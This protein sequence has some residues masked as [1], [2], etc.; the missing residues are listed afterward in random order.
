MTTTEKIIKYAATAFAA[1]IAVGIVVT[2][3]EFG[4]CIIHT[5]SGGNSNTTDKST[6]FSVEKVTSI[7]IDLNVGTLTIKESSDNEQILVDA[8]HVAS[9]Y[10][11]ELSNNGVLTVKNKNIKSKFLNFFKRKSNITIYIPHNTNLD[12]LTVKVGVGDIDL[13]DCISD[14]MT[15]NNGVGD[16]TLSSIKGNT[17]K[18]DLGIGDIDIKDS[19][20]QNADIDSGIGDFTMDLNGDVED[21]DIKLDTGIGDHKINDKSTKKYSGMNALY[22]IKLD[23]GIGDCELKFT[24]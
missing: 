9:S 13:E 12:N 16:V 21:Y 7:E 3:L 5:F 6:D 22:K 10:T 19:I 17:V 11:C 2:I 18:F 8:E 24:K 20:I 4:F 1:L 14:S 15:I 23:T